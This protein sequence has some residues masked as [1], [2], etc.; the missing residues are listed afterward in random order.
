M[1][2]KRM[3]NRW[4]LRGS[5]TWQD[6]TQDVGD[7]AF[8]DPTRLRSGGLC[9]NCDGGI[10]SQGSG[11]GSGAKG[12]I[13]INS[14]WAYNVTGAYQIPVIET[15]LGFNL[16][17]RQGY[18]IPYVHRVSVSTGFKPVLVTDDIDEYRL[19][20]LMN[21]DLRLAK[22]LRFGPV[23]FTVSAD[24]FNVLNR[25][26]ELQRNVT[27]NSAF[28][29]QQNRITELLSPRVFRLGARFTF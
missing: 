27:S 16:T 12:G 19:P 23:G 29:T 1:A 21:L 3:S 25:N 15:S 18:P 13:Y 11:T 9:S 7:D 20:N 8:I 2:T 4:M 24:V 26:T 17:G 10:V 5:F 14:K 22:D 6:W 28:R